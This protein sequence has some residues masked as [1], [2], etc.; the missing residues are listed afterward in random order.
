M[1]NN[2]EEIIE[3]LT[4]YKKAEVYQKPPEVNQTTGET[5]NYISSL[6]YEEKI[7]EI[8][9]Y[10][11]ENNYIS[12]EYYNRDNYPEF[13]EED[14]HSWNIDNL[15][16]KRISYLILRTHNVERMFEGAIDNLATSGTYLNLVKRIKQLKDNK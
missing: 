9:K 7:F 5:I 11:L 4:N 10:L 2:I 13:F 15:D 8:P 12:Q 16:I 1:F 6:I 14:W 3:Y